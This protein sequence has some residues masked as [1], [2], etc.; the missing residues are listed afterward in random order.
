M[1]LFVEHINAYDDHYIGEDTENEFEFED[2]FHKD[3]FD[4]SNTC[5]NEFGNEDHVV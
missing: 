4:D 3:E 1:D 2:G 5:N